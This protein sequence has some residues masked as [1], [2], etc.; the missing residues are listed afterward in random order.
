MQVMTVLGPIS[1]DRLGFTQPHEHLLINMYWVSGAINDLLNDEDLAV[2]EALLFKESGGTSLVDV[3][4][5]GLDRDPEALK[6]I[7]ERTGLNVIMG[8][9]WY[10]QPYYPGEIDRRS[11]NDL[12]AEMI[13][14]LTEGVSDTGIK[15]GIIGEIGVNLDYMTAQ[16]ERVLRAAARAHKATGAAIS[17]HGEVSPIGLLQL[18][19]LEEEGVDLRKVIVGH[20]DSYLRLDYHEAIAE[21]GAYVEYDGI[22]RSHIY[23]D[24]RRVSMLVEMIG[25][26]HVERLLLSTDRCWRS[27]LHAYGGLGYDHILVNFIPMLKQAGISDEQIHIMTVENPKRVL[28]F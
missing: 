2:E 4:D 17:L 15:A 23:P 26:G 7:A 1:P 25:R 12:A 24:E 8:C 20:A 22:G 21:R 13:R 16:E 14:D 11:T 5:I 28:P 19:V 18:D 10:R 6:R 3:T 27:D 9:G